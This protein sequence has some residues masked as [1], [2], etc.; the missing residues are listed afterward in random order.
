M[1]NVGAGAF[2]NGDKIRILVIGD[3]R[4]KRREL[5][6]TSKIFLQLPPNPND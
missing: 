6:K 3:G 4:V 5:T 1:E 2:E